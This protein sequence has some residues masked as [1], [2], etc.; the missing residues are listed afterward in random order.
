MLNVEELNKLSRIVETGSFVLA[1]AELGISQPALSKTVAKLE[2][3][4]GVRLLERRARGVIP[5]AFAEALLRRALPAMAELRAAELE[6]HAMRGGASGAVTVGLAPA[7]AATLLPRV[8]EELR[9]TDRDIC[10]RVIEGLADE[11]TQGVRAGKF[12]F[13][14]TTRSEKYHSQELALQGLHEDRFTACC[15]TK[16]PL[17]RNGGSD[18]QALAKADWVLAPRG[19]LLRAEF[20]ACF[21]DKSVNPPTAVVETSSVSISKSLVLDHGFF[22]FLPAGV[23]AP[24]VRQGLLCSLDL[25]WLQWR[26]KVSLVSRRGQVVSPVQRLVI[27]LFRDAARSM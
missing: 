3:E 26:R 18:P 12:D 20:D 6:I 14:I 16:H 10:L 5:T 11:L 22:S 23:V 13:A 4:L 25:R 15:H 19:G 17:A 24:E 7:A 2:R 1:A 27:G 21:L 9:A 8:I